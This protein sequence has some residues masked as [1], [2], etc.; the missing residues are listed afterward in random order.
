MSR[1]P[2]TAASSPE[3][4][5]VIG[6]GCRLPGDAD[7]PAALW[8]L[9]LRG[10]DAV[11]PPPPERERLWQAGSGGE[12]MPRQAGYLRDVAGFD[13]EFFGVSGR[14]AAVLDPQ[15]RLLLEVA[16]EALEH[17]GMAPDRL[18]GTATGV[19]TGLSYT[20][21]MDQ[22]DG[23]PQE[24]E[25]S[26][27]TNGHSVA[28]GRISYLLGLHGPSVALDTACS[29]SLVALHLA[30]QA[31]RAGDCDLALVGGVTLILRDRTTRTFARMGMLSATGHCRTFDAHADGFVRGEGCGVVV[32]KRLA[33]AVR[34]S[35]RMLAVVYGSAVNQDGRSDGLAAPSVEAQQAVYEAALNAAGLHP[36]DIGL[37]ETHGTGT[38]LGDPT[39]FASLTRVYGRGTGRIALGSVK[40]NLGHLEPAAG[41]AG[42]IK[43]V[44][45][46]QHGLI[47]GNLHFTELNPAIDSE[48]SRL[49][50][51]T[52]TTKWPQPSRPR[53]AA[54]SSFGFS[55]TNAHVLLGQTPLPEPRP[56]SAPSPVPSP[57][58]SAATTPRVFVVPA[59]SAAVLPRAADRLARWLTGPGAD[60][61]LDDVAHTLAMRRSAGRGRL[62][63][64]ASSRR[65]LATALGAFAMDGTVGPRTAAGEVG[66]SVT[67]R[68]VW[69]FS[70]QG[71]QWAGMGRQLLRKE[72]AFADALAE[73]DAL[74][75]AESG[76]PVLPVVRGGQEVTGCGRVQPALFAIQVA[77]AA[78]WRAYGIE[79]AGVIGHSMGEVA[80]A[81]AAG[82]LSLADGVRVICRRSRL[83]ERLAGSGAMATVALPSD[84]VEAEL[85]AGS[86]GSGGVWV[87]V[88]AAPDSTVVTGDPER[89][90][91]LVGFW[92]ARG[93]PA[94][95]VAVDIASHCPH[96]E[97]LLDELRQDLAGIR[98]DQPRV[99]FYSTVLDDPLQVPVLDADYWCANLRRPVRF[100][101]AVAAAAAD[102]HRV[103]VEVAPHPVVAAAVSRN[104]ADAADEVVVVPTLRR[105]E[106]DV[107]VFRHHLGVQHCA[108]VPVD[109]SPLYKD[110]NL[111][112]V[113]TVTFD[114]RHHWADAV[115]APVGR[116]GDGQ[117]TPSAP[118]PGVYRQA[119]GRPVRHC[120]QAGAVTRALP[121]LADHQVGGRV[122]MP[123][124]V[125]CA[126]ALSCAC[127]LY[128]A[129]PDAVEVTDIRFL[130]LLHLSESTG[131]S[132]TV[133]AIGPDRAQCEIFARDG[134]EGDWELQA[135][136][137]LRHT[138]ARPP[139]TVSADTLASRHPVPLEPEDLYAGLRARGLRHGPAF[140]GITH[141]RRARDDKSFWGRLLLPENVREELGGLRVHPVPVDLCAQLVA[142]GAAQQ[143]DSGLILPVA[144]ASVR[145]TSDVMAAQYG[146]ARI[147]EATA[148]GLVGDVRLLD[149]AGRVVLAIDGLRFARR[150]NRQDSRPDRWFLQADWQPVPRLPEPRSSEPGSWLV[151][152][153]GDGSADALADVLTRSGAASE[154]WD[155]PLEDRSTAEVKAMVER[156]LVTD[157]LRGLVVL[158]APPDGAAAN[159]AVTGL[160]RT[161]RLIGA[162]QALAA[163]DITPP[164]LY[165]VTRAARAVGPAEPTDPAQ[166]ALRGLI[167]TLAFEHPDLRATLVDTGPAD[168]WF[169]DLAAELLHG[170]AEDE[171]ALREEARYAARLAYAPLSER[172]RSVARAC[173][174]RYGTDGCRLRVAS[175]GD[176]DSLELVTSS[177][178]VPGPGEVEVRVEAAGVNFRDV[179]TA[180]GL[181]PAL[182]PEEDVRDRIGFECAGTVTA[183]GPRAGRVQVGDRVMAV[184]LSGG[185]FGTFVTVPAQ[186]TALLLPGMDTTVAAGLPIAYLTAWY[187]LHDVARLLPGERVLIHSATGGT[188]QAAIAVARRL[189][190]E[191]LATAGSEDKRRML[192][193]MG[194]THVMDSRSLDFAEQAR[195]AT[196]GR[197]VD[198]VLNSL[199][200]PAVRAG[201]EALRPF[202]RFVELGVRDILADAP[203]G[204][205]PL[206]HNVSFSTVD[207]MGLH[208][209]RPARL[210]GLL[211]D[212][213]GEFASGAL[214]PLHVTR[215]PLGQ[216]VDAFRLMAAAGHKG[217]L[218]LTVPERG[219]TAARRPDGPAPVRPEGAYIITGG[220]RGV[221]L[222]T[223][224]WLAE[225]GAGHLVLNGRTGPSGRTARTLAALRSAGTR[226]TVVLGDIAEPGTA[227]RLTA[228]AAAEGTQL[229][230]VVHSAMVLEDAAIGTIKDGSLNRVWAPKAAG[231][232]R[233]HHA[234]AEQS[235]DWFVVFSS[236]A[237]LLGNPGQGAY[238]AANAWLDAFA[239]WR[240]AGG[241]PTLAV[242]W[243]PWGE[244]GAAT[245]FADR[246]YQT[247]PTAEGL[248]ALRDL[249]VHRRVQ[250]GVIPGEP[251]TFVPAAGRH[252][253]FFARLMSGNPEAA[254]ADNSKG[255]VREIREHLKSL[256]SQ[257][258]RRAAVEAALAEH[259]RAVLRLESRKLD[260]Q[261]PLSSLG[262][263]SL[264]SM[265]L[266][267]RVETSLGVR[268]PGNFVWK[269]ST[270]A[271]L[272]AGVTE[273][274]E[275]G[276]V[277][278]GGTNTEAS[279][280]DRADS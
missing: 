102:R 1:R 189:G 68:P 61:P 273:R 78:A 63:V 239:A 277:E 163:S 6:M 170:G 206:R 143:A 112:D 46:L 179:L 228:A 223:A 132:T 29:S 230:G 13:A 7:S 275:A 246:G 9:L 58:R 120:W 141:L 37:I 253:P 137:V 218:V 90:R 229:R 220:L 247:I 135:T 16:W 130:T 53:L 255:T 59:G 67:R 87:A 195:A 201:L 82:G 241:Q 94:A 149:G 252:S 114:R 127:Q 124:A 66:A 113:P 191:V 47:P 144:V 268:L 104:L 80:A 133:T 19:F 205:A 101:D 96:V 86:G 236:M 171:V 142:A 99:R 263:D 11:G 32:V 207:L 31:L 123:G 204:M 232:W 122:V 106:D 192:R 213:A 266:R 233:L 147:T 30:C 186:L 251:R 248:Q 18:A 227:E 84:E 44:L 187:A 258:A 174:V 221:G 262:F 154:V 278:A 121:W 254:G 134:E 100:A 98:P 20:D 60:V 54:V 194:I 182:A 12:P 237:S 73:A 235:L 119:P 71:S 129:E 215:F 166:G 212:V 159:P 155:M 34:D 245:G 196:S 70:G 190:A 69:I 25:G 2:Q 138:G 52:R 57:R 116:W 172:E 269:N 256:P 280:G 72:P 10:Q 244:T 261:T 64:T 188:G 92:Q 5:A 105:D 128:G 238:A 164:R 177:R 173:T 250:A 178:Q 148:D 181:L 243:G 107:A 234:T 224:C 15:H 76:F 156:R 169:H 41:V 109:W 95:L 267:T 33:D 216:T 81:V 184:L 271:A 75:R 89:V 231:A 17:A 74:I 26:V 40:T 219:E 183:V 50:V 27:L 180:M 91:Q 168:T 185:A 165:S 110:G 160:L 197:G 108:G 88:V 36:E 93:I 167:R 260:P 208:R 56:L 272:A 193:G 85:G 249:L 157:P 14:E 274:L 209:D 176:L 150:E 35:D 23:H 62:A 83:L 214:K 265:E 125:S 200:G 203:L 242:N 140:T 38:P 4:V 202:G 65:E 79:P 152:G 111:A 175:P 257:N 118:L 97:P 279:T 103:Y 43:A 259:V 151:I 225:Q 136:A 210:A 21:Y 198:V 211:R 39:E 8:N 24:L 161:R 217:K 117:R 126:V 199:S 145:V 77:L 264:L 240:T 146:H 3:A 49:F 226:V 139:R 158:C 276:N 42:L 153:E 48:G 22:L 51:P 270:L 131:L 222:A 45:C 28:P 115:S 162:A 55:G